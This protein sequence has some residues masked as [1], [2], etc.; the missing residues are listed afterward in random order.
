MIPYQFRS[1]GNWREM[2]FEIVNDA[3]QS[4][5]RIRAW[6]KWD[7]SIAPKFRHILMQLKSCNL[8]L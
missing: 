4:I 5:L 7:T 6:G 8:L 3:G 1:T 2:G